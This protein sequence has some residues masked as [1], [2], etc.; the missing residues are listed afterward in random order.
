[1]QQSAGTE[2]WSSAARAGERAG[3]ELCLADAKIF[4][5]PMERMLW[6]IPWWLCWYKSENTATTIALYIYKKANVMVQELW[7]SK[8]IQRSLKA[9][10]K[11]STLYS[12]VQ[13]IMNPAIYSP[14]SCFCCFRH[15][16][17]LVSVCKK[18]K[19]AFFRK[20]NKWK[21]KGL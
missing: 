13:N 5:T 4:F 17:R 15:V 3:W 14:I 2:S 8:A 6:N 11:K 18:K 12:K 10:G 1:M 20:Q 19:S 16:R 7:L 21:H 9:K